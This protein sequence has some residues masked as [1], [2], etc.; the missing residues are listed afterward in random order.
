MMPARIPASRP[1]RDRTLVIVV[2]SLSCAASPRV[3]SMPLC[4]SWLPPR[5]QVLATR[6]FRGSRPRGGALRRRCQGLPASPESLVQGYHIGRYGGL[7]LCQV[8]L[9]GKQRPLRVE[10][11][12]KR[13]E[14]GAI[15]ISGERYR[16]LVRRHRVCQLDA[17]HLL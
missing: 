5:C 10:Y 15:E 6:Q 12:Q 11:V 3:C 2:T 1:S 7:A 4:H 9:G 13:A 14:T 8:A 16:L 17:A